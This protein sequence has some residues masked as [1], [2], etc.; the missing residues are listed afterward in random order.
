MAARKERVCQK[1]QE[2][3]KLFCKADE[4]LICVVCDQSQEHKDHEIIPV[5]EASQ[6]FKDQFCDCVEMLQKK[7]K[8]IL[9]C[10]ASILEESNHLL[11]QTKGERQKTATK[12]R[13]LHK[14]LD[15]QENLFL[16]QV[17]EHLAELCEELSSL[18]SLIQEVEEK[19]QQPATELLQVRG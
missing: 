3:L 7:R 5:E 9:A 11:K 1:H 17:K 8:E 2:P 14:F 18:D 12:F 16:A 19:C 15:Q 10:K 6:E 13:Q 4:T